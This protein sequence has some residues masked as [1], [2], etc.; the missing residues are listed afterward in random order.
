M[1]EIDMLPA[2]T[3]RSL[4]RRLA[5]AL[6]VAAVALGG[7]ACTGEPSDDA[8]GTTGRL[9]TPLDTSGT[10]PS[11]TTGTGP[12]GA[13]PNAAMG[14][15]AMG[16][17]WDW[18]RYTEFQPYLKTLSG[19]FTYYEVVWCDVEEEQGRPDWS[20]LDRIAKRSQEVGVT[21][22][23]KL[24][25]GRCWATS[26][27]AAYVRGSKKKTESAMP[28]DMSAY[29]AWVRSAV[30][31]YSKLGVHKY[32]IE[33]E[34]NSKSFWAGTPEDFGRL[35]ESAAAE[36]RA[37]DP[38]AKVVDA[39]LSSTTYGYGLSDWLLKEGRE[40]DAIAAYNSYYERRIG[41][42][43]DKIPKVK[44]RAGLEE[45]LR[46]EQGARNL[47]YLSLMRDLAERKVTDIRQIHF[48]EKYTS[49]P[50]L[51]SYLRANT[52]AT[53]PIEAWEV[54]SF[55]RDAANDTKERTSEVLK[56]VG[57]VL[58]EGASLA[59][60]LPLAFDP[61]GRNPDE[62]R[63]GLLEPDGGVRDAGRLFQS[64][65]SASRGAKVVRVSHDGIAGV[66]FDKGGKST[67][68]VWSDRG[69]TLTLSSGETAAPAMETGAPSAV[70]KVTVGGDPLRLS[71][72]RTTAVFVGGQQ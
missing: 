43:G 21:L 15:S 14:S 59:I 35:A 56:T 53:T 7:S 52:P 17:K 33:N 25:V 29:R 26:G 13:V 44:E 46:S 8:S 70:G 24:R 63:F 38:K 16:A 31:R 45:V 42:R 49:V 41:T 6:V 3:R 55:F 18:G 58:A 34:I 51:F 10:D 61:G 11:S 1:T 4:R 57:L 20:S 50:M 12:G 40:A 2:S 65:V 27:D 67:A 48:Y 47:A 22:M 60:W 69:A 68:F 9:A 72:L 28:Q 19:G 71:L 54:G 36:V 32:A 39:G 23:L 64:M 37:A 30:S 62:P 66:G 5:S